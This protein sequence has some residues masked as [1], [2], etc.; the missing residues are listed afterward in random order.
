MTKK[1]EGLGRKQ[2]QTMLDAFRV[3]SG[4][5]FDLKKFKTGEVAAR[6]RFG[7]EARR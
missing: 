6:P 4:E 2:T 1:H 3:T 5:N 7:Q